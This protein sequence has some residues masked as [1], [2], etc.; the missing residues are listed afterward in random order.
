M[1]GALHSVEGQ[2]P[3]TGHDAGRC[4]ALSKR[5]G[6]M[7]GSRECNGKTRYRTTLSIETQL[8]MKP[9][10]IEF[11]V[12]NNTRQGL[13]GVSGG[14]DGVE[15]DATDARKQIEALEAEVARL[16]KT[17]LRRRRWIKR[18]NIRQIET[19]QAG[20]S[21]NLKR[22][23]AA[24]RRAR[25]QSQKRPKIRQSFLLMQRKLRVHSTD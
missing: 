22:S 9:V 16:S 10:E 11:L 21:R 25:R 15:K 5:P 13:S 7:Y 12:K 19:L 20:N 14:I 4:P 2:F 8:A 1:V 3:D 23:W 6:R 24:F 18:D 17:S